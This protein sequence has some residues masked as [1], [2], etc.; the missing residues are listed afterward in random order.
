MPSALRSRLAAL[1]AA[2]LLVAPAIASAHPGGDTQPAA[3]NAAL[4]SSVVALGGGADHFSAAAF[5]RALSAPAANED[6]TLRAAV[7]TAMVDRFD[8]VFTYVVLDGVGTMKRGGNPLPGSPSTDAKAVAA[9]LYQAGL[10]DGVFDV[11]H[12]FDTLFSSA[13]HNHA[14]VAVGRK[15]GAGGE[16]AYHLVLGRLVQ[17]LGKP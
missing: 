8:D 15:Y 13:V 9:A 12:L 1:V 10:H 11:E 17:D 14:M 3:Q 4:L 7:G 16:T 6:Q 5:R 2:V